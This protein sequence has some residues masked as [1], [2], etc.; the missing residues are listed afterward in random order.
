MKIPLSPVFSLA[1]AASAF[2]LVSIAP[3]PAAAE[4]VY[5]YCAM[6]VGEEE[7]QNC[8]YDTLAQCRAAMSGLPGYCQPNPRYVAVPPAVPVKKKP[9]HPGRG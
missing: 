4:I 1:L 9:R 8:G 7:A 5:P 6:V 3:R 2:G